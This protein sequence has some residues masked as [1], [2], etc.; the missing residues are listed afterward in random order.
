MGSTAKD[1]SLKS[2]TVVSQ[3]GSKGHFCV[4]K[5][6]T[7]HRKDVLYEKRTIQEE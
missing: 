2:A 7:T 5:K 4:L 6:S 3:T 1:N